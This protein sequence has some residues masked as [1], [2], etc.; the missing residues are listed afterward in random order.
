MKKIYV[1]AHTDLD[2]IGVQIIGRRYAEAEGLPVEI[3][4]CNYDDI[5]SKVTK[6]LQ[7]NIQDDYKHIAE[8]IIGDISVDKYTASLV[9]KAYQA[10]VPVIL[11]DHHATAE[12][13]NKYPWAYVTEK[14]HDIFVC[15]TYLLAK[16]FPNIFRQMHIFIGL[17]NEWDTWQWRVTGNNY[18]KNLNALYKLLGTEKFTDYILSLNWGRGI[19]TNQDLFTEYAQALVNAHE[20]LVA[21]TA[22]NCEKS[23]WVGTLKFKNSHGKKI[24]FKVGVIFCNN[25]ISEIADYV[26]EVHPELDFIMIGC[27]PKVL[28]F[29][30]QKQLPIPL[31]EIAKQVTGSGGGHP[32]AAGSIISTR[33]FQQGFYNF[34]KTITNGCSIDT[35]APITDGNT[36][37]KPHKK[38]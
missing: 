19:H 27:L 33:Q 37:S 1:F 23:M 7:E 17:V 8:I 16:E 26:L 29:R 20:M 5:S 32:F 12:W 25:D 10:G 34:L 30:T 31:G 15:G 4:G 24:P 9:D 6:F 21:K 2:G 11:R 14:D 38:S 28:S 22:H 3:Y 36:V 35:F 18:A 13:L